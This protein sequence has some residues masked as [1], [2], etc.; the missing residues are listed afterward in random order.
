MDGARPTTGTKERKG[1]ANKTFLN[2]P[3]MMRVWL[4]LALLASSAMAQYKVNPNAL[5][6]AFE[7]RLLALCRRSP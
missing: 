7:G 4:L 1:K 5:N 6:R 3:I 2:H